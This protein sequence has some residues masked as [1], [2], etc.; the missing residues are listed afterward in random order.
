LFF[1][2]PSSP[3]PHAHK[4]NDRAGIYRDIYFLAGAGVIWLLHAFT[5]KTQKT[6][7]QAIDVARRRLK[8]VQS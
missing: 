1:C 3:A 5:K 8:E 6:P 4:S 7:E 2:A